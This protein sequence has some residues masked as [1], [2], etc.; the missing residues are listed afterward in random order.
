M[1]VKRTNAN[2]SCLYSFYSGTIQVRMYE[3]MLPTNDP[4]LISPLLEAFLFELLCCKIVK[5]FFWLLIY[6][7]FWYGWENIYC[8][9][10]IATPSQEKTNELLTLLF[11]LYSI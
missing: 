9:L 5:S 8:L 10:I 6:L 11:L 4:N 1:Q 2:S 7:F 3:Y